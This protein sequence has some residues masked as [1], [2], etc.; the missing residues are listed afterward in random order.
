MRAVMSG[1]CDMISRM[2]RCTSI[3]ETTDLR[4]N[5]RNIL[6]IQIYQLVNTLTKYR[7]GY[8][9]PGKGTGTSTW[10]GTRYDTSSGNTRYLE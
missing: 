7:A 3:G 1:W 4:S 9:V 6:L 8:Q 2:T 5:I 10:P